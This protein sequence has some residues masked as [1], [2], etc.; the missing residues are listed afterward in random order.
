MSLLNSLSTLA[1]DLVKDAD[2][3]VS[4]NRLYL[5]VPNPSACFVCLFVFTCNNVL[6]KLLC[7][8]VLYLMA[9]CHRNCIASCLGHSQIFS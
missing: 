1:M 9:S 4:Q 2:N 6:K 3:F 7:L 5:D 8:I